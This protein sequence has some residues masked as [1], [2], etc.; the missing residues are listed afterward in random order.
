[1]IVVKRLLLFLFCCLLSFLRFLRLLGHVPLRNPKAQ[2][3]STIDRHKSRLHQ[4]CKFNTARFKEGKRCRGARP[5]RGRP[6]VFDSQL[7]QRALTFARNSLSVELAYPRSFRWTFGI[8]TA[9][10]LRTSTSSPLGH[11]QVY[12]NAGHWSAGPSSPLWVICRHA[13]SKAASPLHP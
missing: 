13:Q 6:P 9:I 5:G 7:R 4:N 12:P 1:M 11:L 8:G 3:K 10:S 2:C